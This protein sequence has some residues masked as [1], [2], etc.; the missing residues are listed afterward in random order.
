VMPVLEAVGFADVELYG[1]HAEPDGDFP[2]VPGHVSNPENVKVFDAIISRGQEIGADLILASDPDCDRIGAAAPLTA[3]AAGHWGVFNGNQIGVLLGDYLLEQRRSQL[4]PEHYVVTTLV[5]TG[6]LRRV[7]DSY[8]VKTFDNNQVGFKWI[9]GV[10]DREGPDKFIYGTEESHG[11]MTGTYTRDKDGA[12]AA[13]LMAEL[14]AKVKADGQ[15]LHE[16]LDSLYWQHGYHAERQV[17]IF[18]EG[19]EGMKEMLALMDRLRSDPPKS[20]AGLNVTQVRDYQNGVIIR[21]DT[22]PEPFDGAHGNLVILD[23][24]AKGNYVAVRPS[25]TEPKVKFYMFAYEAAEQLHN[26]ETTKEEM[27]ARLDG[28]ESDL[29]SYAK[30]S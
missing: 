22:A 26:L 15:T 28:F 24:S 29:R 25:G 12:V 23:L 21:S 13:M 3:D 27:A 30:G 7:A 16:K 11:Y 6:M 14:A 9:A 17:S 19:A 5:T 4:T 8:G 20:I 1:P 2:N 10:I 18:M